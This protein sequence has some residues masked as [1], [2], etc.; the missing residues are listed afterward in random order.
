MDCTGARAAWRVICR[1]A[2]ST[3]TL[4]K[5]KQQRVHQ[6]QSRR[7]IHLQPIANIAAGAIVK[8]GQSAADD[9]NAGEGNEQHGAGDQAHQQP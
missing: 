7:Q 8:R 2:S 3:V 9:V 6:Q 4:L 5:Q 1:R